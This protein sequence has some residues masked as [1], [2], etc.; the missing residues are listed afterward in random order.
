MT[1]SI[2]QLYYKTKLNISINTC[3]FSFFKFIFF[4]YNNFSIENKILKPQNQYN[5]DGTNL[6]NI[7]NTGSCINN[8]T[9]RVEL[10]PLLY[11]YKYSSIEYS[12]NL[13]KNVKLSTYYNSFLN[14]NNLFKLNLLLNIL[15]DKNTNNI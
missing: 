9:F 15:S 10:F 4:K 6:V 12:D 11:K 1:G 13:L 8:M 7:I 5:I 3:D 14:E 2:L